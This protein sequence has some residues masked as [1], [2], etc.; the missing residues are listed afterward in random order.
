[1]II[2]TYLWEPRIPLHESYKD[3]QA[4]IRNLFSSISNEF[5]P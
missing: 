5:P 1:M 3:L 4:N 2:I